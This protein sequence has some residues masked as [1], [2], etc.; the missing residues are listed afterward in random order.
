[1][2]ASKNKFLEQQACDHEIVNA[3][4][5]KAIGTL[6]VKP[7]SVLWKPKGAKGAKAWYSVTLDDVV[8]YIKGKNNRVSK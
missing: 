5:G 7:S 4:D 8:E 3:D 6:R 1:M 2:P